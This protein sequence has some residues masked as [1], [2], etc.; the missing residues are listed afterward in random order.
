MLIPNVSNTI[1]TPQS[2]RVPSDGA[3]VVKDSVKVRPTVAQAEPQQPSN[4]QLKS[5]VDNINR[6]L[7]QTNMKM[8][9]SIDSSTKKPVVKMMD[10]ETG[11]LIRQFPSEEVLAI[12]SSIDQFLEFQQGLLLKTKA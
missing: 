8:E 3:A 11:E 6:A 5:A 9:L 12:A 4:V 7:Q 2:V 10:A 1:Q